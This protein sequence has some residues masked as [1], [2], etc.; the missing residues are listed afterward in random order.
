MNGVQRVQ[1]NGKIFLRLLGISEVKMKMK[2]QLGMHFS[3][4]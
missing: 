4:V 2:V 3:G 1:V